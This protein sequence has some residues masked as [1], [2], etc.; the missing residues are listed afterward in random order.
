MAAVPLETLRRDWVEVPTLGDLV[1]RR[2]ARWPETDAVVFPERR[3][4]GAEL[5]ASSVA[6]AR[7][8]L[9]LGLVRGETVAILMPNELPYLHVLYGC[10]MIGVRALLVNA[11]YKAYELAYVLEHADVAAVV[12]SD[13][14][15]EYV[16]F[17]PLLAEA[18]ARRPALLRHLVL[19]GSSSPAGFVDRD[20]FDA[21]G[22]GVEP[23]RVHDL[24]AAIGVRDV[25]ILMYTSGT[26]AQPK[27]CLITH[28][29]LVRT[30]ISVA[31]RFGFTDA[32]RFWDPLPFFHMGAML[33]LTATLHAGG[34]FLTMTH[35][36]P[37][38][39]LRQIA[40]ER[41][42]FIFPCF[43][44]ITRSLIHDPGFASTDLSTVRGLL[45]TGPAESLQE[46][47]RRFG[48]PAVTSYGLTEAGGVIAFGHLDDPPEQRS[49]T[50]GRPFRG[51]EVRIVD[52]ESEQDLPAGETGS[53]LVRGVG[54]FDGYYKDP[55]HT[56]QALAGGWLHTGD[57]GRVDEDGRVAYGGRTKDMLKVGGENVSALE[58]EAYVGTHPDV[59]V[60]AVVGVP[61]PR[62]QEVPAA[63]IERVPGSEV[64]EDDLID[65]CRGQIA[66]FKVPR[67]VRF[68]EEWP[69]SATKI[70]KHRLR[71][72]LL[73]E[74]G[75]E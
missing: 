18:T 60:V 57:L 41:S 1:V 47:E 43:P 74:L 56:A 6:S 55:E 65:Y 24:R 16:D 17:V 54:L 31:G 68:V 34:A 19:L 35:F 45:D 5:L 25:G 37:G 70:Q 48:V 63:F 39:A 51:M 26:T 12:T 52:P 8:L 22:A 71:A 28:E 75:L 11:R 64:S 3:E 69:L 73:S 61:D 59:K 4:T 32:E 38:A 23:A 7:S 15:S 21:A 14:V 67:Y 30:G 2:A 20:A 36:E 62:Y 72:S 58:V 44:T 66:S 13:T 29:A 9:G 27:G 50:G 42:T 33:Q 53:V 40:G 10:A 46:V 49:S